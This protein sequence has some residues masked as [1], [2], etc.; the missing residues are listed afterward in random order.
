[1]L[2]S[3][4]PSS[5]SLLVEMSSRSSRTPRSRR[6]GGARRSRCRAAAAGRRVLA[7]HGEV[8]VE[9]VRPLDDAVVLAY[10]L[11]ESQARISWSLEV[12]L[13]CT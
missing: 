4:E 11:C 2:M 6:R 8:D 3:R 7:M 10:V 9:P 13:L 12:A 1:L 5:T